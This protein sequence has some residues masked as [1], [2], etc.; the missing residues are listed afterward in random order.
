MSVRI[1]DIP[2]N[3]RPR[4][5][6][7]NNGVEALGNDELIAI[8]LRSGTNNMSVK[9]LSNHILKEIDNIFNLKEMTYEKLLKIKGIGPA[10][11][12]QLIACIE[13]GKRMHKNCNNIKEIKVISAQNIY[14][15]YK[16]ILLDKKQEYFYC[17]YL[18]NK[19]KIIK[20][21]LL[22]VGTI[23]ESIVH[24]R[25]VFKEAYLSS[26]TSIIC[27]HNHPSGVINPSKNDIELTK[28]LQSASIQLGINLLDHIIIGS[29][30]YYSFRENGI[31]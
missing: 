6:L 9:E 15:Y 5:R 24:P 25:E 1:E 29:K 22:F 30:T 27:V 16:D 10:K 7:I 12:C 17:V 26:S 18:D 2:I 31:I 21:K 20:D 11:A 19:N 23:N 8:L 14:D 4:E 13:L 28:Q 3:D